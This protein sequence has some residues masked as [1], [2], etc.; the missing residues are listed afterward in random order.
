MSISAEE[1][2]TLECLA[3]AVADCITSTSSKNNRYDNYGR[4]D[5]AILHMQNWPA[6]AELSSTDQKWRKNGRISQT[7]FFCPQY[8]S[9]Y[10]NN[11]TATDHIKQF[12]VKLIK[13]FREI[14]KLIQL[15]FSL[16]VPRLCNKCPQFSLLVVI[17]QLIRI[18]F[19]VNAKCL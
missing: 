12:A 4:R 15:G 11:Y 8:C 2:S 6:C 3:C 1:H 16:Q 19:T 14:C 5:S 7:D 18:S 9:K 17:L 13:F 10:C